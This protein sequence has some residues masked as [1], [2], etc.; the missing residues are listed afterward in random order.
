MMARKNHQFSQVLIVA[1]GIA[2]IFVGCKAALGSGSPIYVVASGSMVPT[3][4]VNDVIFVQGNLP[5]DNIKVGDVI[6]FVNPS[7]KGELIVH[8]VAQILNQ[9]PIEIR[10]KGDA[11]THSIAGI[12]LPITKNNYIGKVTLV[13]PQVGLLGKIFPAPIN[14]IVIASILGIIALLPFTRQNALH[15]KISRF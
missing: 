3:L 5:F 4:H 7:D 8:R 11:N 6:A 9:N 1:L 2:I 15:Q 13:I 12:D 14:Y 10:T